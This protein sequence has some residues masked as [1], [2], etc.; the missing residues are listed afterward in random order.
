V[1]IFSLHHDYQGTG[2]AEMTLGIDER[3]SERIFSVF[4]Q[5]LLDANRFKSGYTTALK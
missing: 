2:F 5:P 4:F 1:N 3:Q